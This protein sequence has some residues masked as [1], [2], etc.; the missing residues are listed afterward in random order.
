MAE[1]RVRRRL[2][3]D[4][5]PCADDDDGVPLFADGFKCIEEGRP[6]DIKWIGH[7]RPPPAIHSRTASPSDGARPGLVKRSTAA[8]LGATNVMESS[9]HVRSKTT[10][11]NGPK[12]ITLVPA[13]VGRS[14]SDAAARSG[15]STYTIAS[16]DGAIGAI[17]AAA[18][19]LVTA[20]LNRL[21]R[22]LPSRFSKPR[23]SRNERASLLLRTE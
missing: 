13:S 14:F 21:V 18:S 4:K 20:Y 22:R 6:R 2:Y 8:W 16:R 1:P 11:S 17:R 5:S 12:S 3:G 15:S 10:E 23:G 19:E 7:F 9:F